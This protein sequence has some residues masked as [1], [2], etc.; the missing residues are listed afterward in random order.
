[1][2]GSRAKDGA[3]AETVPPEDEAPTAELAIV[4]LGALA[5]ADRLY[6]RLL[7]AQQHGERLDPVDVELARNQAGHAKAQLERLTRSFAAGSAGPDHNA[8][9][10]MRKAIARLVSYLLHQCKRHVSCKSQSRD[11]GRQHHTEGKERSS[12]DHSMAQKI[13]YQ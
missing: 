6:A 2:N 12:H 3:V 1:M 11:L 8:A 10:A 7:V 5:L 13:Q 4:A 9:E